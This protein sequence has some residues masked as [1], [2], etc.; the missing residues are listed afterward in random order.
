MFSL[1]GLLVCRQD[2]IKATERIS[3]FLR[4]GLGPEQISLTF[5]MIFSHCLQH[6]EVFI[7]FIFQGIMQ[8]L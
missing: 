2:N 1:V 7:F 3:T 5:R 6:R 8:S 4:K